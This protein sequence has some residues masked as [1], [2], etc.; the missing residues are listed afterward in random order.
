MPAA[1]IWRAVA[2]A[3][4]KGLG[5]LPLSAQWAALAGGITGIVLEL[6]KVFTKG[7]FPLSAVGMGL[8][9]V[10]SFHTCL[11][12]S[13]GAFLFAIAGRMKP[14]WATPGDKNTVKNQEP[15]CA[16]IIAGGALVGIAVILL[17]NFVFAA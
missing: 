13:L 11:A 6:V 16:G 15:I 2:E 17:E 3:L 14:N 10:I 5:E 9:F 12:M 7:R 1:T 4:T 8:A